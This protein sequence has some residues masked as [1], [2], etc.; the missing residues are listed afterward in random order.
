M[1]G[2][3][4]WDVVI[5]H[6]ITGHDNGVY[7]NVGSE[8]DCQLLCLRA[9]GFKCYSIEYDPAQN[10][11]YLSTKSHSSATASWSILPAITYE[12]YDVIEIGQY[13]NVIFML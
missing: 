13:I 5:G 4:T 11:C 3:I 2:L 12:E 8:Y 9:Q 7:S 1:P 6:T 10:I